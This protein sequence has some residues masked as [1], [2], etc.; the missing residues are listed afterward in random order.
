MWL[1]QALVNSW[2]LF[3]KTLKV[4]VEYDNLG[5][6][7]YEVVKNNNSEI[8]FKIKQIKKT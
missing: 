3:N 1:K 8:G 6:I 7:I 4:Q 2:S 5:L